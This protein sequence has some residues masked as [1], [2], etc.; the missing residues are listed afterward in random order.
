MKK[1]E[2]PQQFGLNAGQKEVNYAVDSTGHYTLEQSAGWEAKTIALRQAWEAIVDQLQ[3][4]LAAIKAGRKSPLAYHMV[5]NQMDPVLLS[6]YSGISR[7]RVK[8]HLKPAV[9]AR[10][11]AA[12]LAPY[13][14]LFN[15]SIEQ[16]RSVP[17][18]PDLELFAVDEIE[19][20][21]P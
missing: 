9:F 2:V 20:D 15:I 7:W 8:R 18:Q 11:K 1:E 16:L 4:E 19:A 3:R 14:E 12:A 17:E 13:T 6:Q 21:T 10:L 5:K